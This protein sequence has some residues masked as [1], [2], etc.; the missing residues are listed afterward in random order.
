MY[1]TGLNASSP[2]STPL[3]LFCSEKRVLSAIKS[4]RAVR[5]DVIRALAN[6]VSRTVSSARQLRSVQDRI[7]RS[8]KVDCSPGKVMRVAR[9]TKTSSIWPW[10][11]RRWKSACRNE[12]RVLA[13]DPGR[14]L[15][16]NQG[17]DSTARWPFLPFVSNGAEEAGAQRL[18][19]LYP[20]FRR[21]APTPISAGLAGHAP[22]DT[23]IPYIV[24]VKKESGTIWAPLTVRRQR[25]KI[26]LP[27][28]SM[29]LL[30]AN[31]GVLS[32]KKC[33]VKALSKTDV[34]LG[35][36]AEL[37]NID[38]ATSAQL[39]RAQQRRV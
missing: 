3:T 37:G 13:P 27:E 39:L 2:P 22:A 7:L 16:R 20:K 5:N 6:L 31:T 10:A 25:T 36:K 24:E 29:N 11:K 12:A 9:T 33:R 15:I 28:K 38:E 35:S 19:V 17:L 1:N 30:V 14:R 8:T 26:R 34:W 32:K 21:L 4:H 18:H 23:G